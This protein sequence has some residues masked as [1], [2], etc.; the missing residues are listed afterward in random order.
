MRMGAENE[1]PS[2]IERL[3][4]SVVA[5]GLG[6]T[7]VSMSSLLPAAAA[8]SVGAKIAFSRD[9]GDES[10]IFVMNQ[11][12]TKPTDVSKASGGSP[13]WSADGSKLAF[14][15]SR[16]TRDRPQVYVMSADGSHQTRLTHDA[17]H[18]S[19]PSWSPDGTK[20][21]F[22]GEDG[23]FVLTLKTKAVSR[24][25]KD[26][27]G[28]PAW[29]PDGATIVFE[30]PREVPSPTNVTGTDQVTEIWTMA[31]DGSQPQQLTSPPVAFSSANLTIV[32]KDA[33]PRW[34]PD[35]TRIA[36]ESN[37][38]N[39][40]GIYEM[41]ADGSNIIAVTHPQGID[42]FP[43]WSPDGTKI[44]FTRTLEPVLS[45][46]DQI[47]SVSIDGSNPTALTSS[48]A[49]ATRPAWQPKNGVR[50]RSSPTR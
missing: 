40:N 34:S 25:T 39:N 18:D 38:A 35:G 45:A 10:H 8:P 33:F 3:V 30:R 49:G 4:F 32:G 27:G 47:Y 14:A 7:L 28:E 9:Q 44:A 42:A 31:A 1:P 19:N 11:D 24:L 26:N 12:G 15:S 22:E 43:S 21:V 37:R 6:G 13:A 50:A 29:S 23:I 48:A 41:N 46:T 2:L 5:L 17:M 20:I 16:A 36:F